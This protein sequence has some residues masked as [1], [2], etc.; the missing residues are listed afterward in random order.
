VSVARPPAGTLGRG[1]S[2]EQR[3]FGADQTE[4]RERESHTREGNGFD[5]PASQRGQV[6]GIYAIGTCMLPTIVSSR[7]GKNN[8]KEMKNSQAGDKPVRCSDL[9][10]S[11]CYIEG[12]AV[13]ARV[14]ASCFVRRL[15]ERGKVGGVLWPF[16]RG[17]S[18][19]LGDVVLGWRDM[20]ASLFLRRK[21][22][23]MRESSAQSLG[24]MREGALGGIW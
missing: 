21:V 13:G 8:E 16:G 23:A 5:L 6:M 2:N 15:V 20:R 7:R 11:E 10:E 24:A 17:S 4:E 3:R 14:Q 12:E 19:V 1:T 18:G 9:K 22:W